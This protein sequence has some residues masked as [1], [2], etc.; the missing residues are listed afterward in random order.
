MIASR[1]TIAGVWSAAPS[2][3]GAWTVDAAAPTTVVVCGPSG[4][5]PDPSPMGDAESNQTMMMRPSDSHRD[6]GGWST[7]CASLAG[8]PSHQMFASAGGN[9]AD[10]GGKQTRPR[11]SRTVEAPAGSPARSTVALCGFLL[12][13]GPK[14]LTSRACYDACWSRSIRRA[15]GSLRISL[16]KLE[17]TRRPQG[18]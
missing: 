9:E 2:S 5:N 3:A 16:A 18:Q 4:D 8:V 13:L 6:R 7:M 17:A 10:C 1:R 14:S 15:S 12:L 11:C